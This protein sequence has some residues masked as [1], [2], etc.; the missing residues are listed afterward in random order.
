MLPLESDT[1]GHHVKVRRATRLPNGSAEDEG[2]GIGM[3]PSQGRIHHRGACLVPRPSTIVHTVAN[4]AAI[5]WSRMG[6]ERG[7]RSD[8]GGEEEAADRC[9][10]HC[11]SACVWSPACMDSTDVVTVHVPSSPHCPCVSDAWCVMCGQC[12]AGAMCVRFEPIGECA[13]GPGDGTT[14]ENKAK[15]PNGFVIHFLFFNRM[16]YHHYHEQQQSFK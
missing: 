8:E 11:S 13:A 12:S 2:K 16:S 1:D 9:P 4:H 7:M 3:P 5:E 15:G 14:A 10:L 6:R